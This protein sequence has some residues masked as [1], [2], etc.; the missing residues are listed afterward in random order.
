MSKLFSN[1]FPLAG[2]VATY[3]FLALWL[4]LT[5]FNLWVG[6]VKAGYSVAEELPIMLLLYGIPAAAA[7][8]VKWK[9]M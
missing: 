3:V 9:L 5:G 8:L 1:Y 6:V 2:T 4:V 7:I